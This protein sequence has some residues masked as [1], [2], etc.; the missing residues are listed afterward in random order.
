VLLYLSI[1]KKNIIKSEGYFLPIRASREKIYIAS[2]LMISYDLGCFI[3]DDIFKQEIL[4]ITAQLRRRNNHDT[5]LL[6]LETYINK[7]FI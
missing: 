6:S 2:G 7:S 1:S 4:F 5:E 3:L